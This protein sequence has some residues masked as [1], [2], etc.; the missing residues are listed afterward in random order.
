MAYLCAEEEEGNDGM[1]LFSH[2][3]SSLYPRGYLVSTIYRIFN[4][5]SGHV[6]WTE[7]AIFAKQ[8]AQ[9]LYFRSAC[10]IKEPYVFVL[11][12]Q[13]ANTW[14]LLGPRVFM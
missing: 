4:I 8:S 13:G 1:A 10:S 5:F 2:S 6:K 3:F 11:L 12:H 7:R 14:A 9:R